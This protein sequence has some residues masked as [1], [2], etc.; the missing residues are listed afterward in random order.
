LTT[1]GVVRLAMAAKEGGRFSNAARVAAFAAAPEP[2]SGN[3]A[4]QAPSTEA[5]KPRDEKFILN[6]LIG[7]PLVNPDSTEP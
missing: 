2:K 4:S 1:T 7:P 3:D 5:N 6:V